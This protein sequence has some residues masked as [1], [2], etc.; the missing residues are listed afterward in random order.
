MNIYK[1]FKKTILIIT[2][3]F[4]TTNKNFPDEK[5]PE[6]N[7]FYNFL[8][9]FNEINNVIGNMLWPLYTFKNIF[10]TI[11]EIKDNIKTN[12][13]VKKYNRNKEELFKKYYCSI[14]KFDN[15]TEN[16]KKLDESLK[17]IVGQE[18]AMKIIK[19]TMIS[20]IEKYYEFDYLKEKKSEEL[21]IG[22]KNLEI[23]LQAKKTKNKEIKKKLKEYEELFIY[24][25]KKYF[26]L[27][28]GC[29]FIYLVGPAGT[30]KTETAIQLV[31]SL[32]SNNNPA[33][34]IDASTIL[35]NKGK[36]SKLLKPI[37]LNNEEYG[38][39][40]KFLRSDLD[41]YIR[42]AKRGVIIFN[43]IDKILQDPKLA[44]DLNE[45]LRGLKDNNYYIDEK[46]E[47]VDVSGFVFIFTSNEKV[48]KSEKDYTGS[49]TIVNSDQSLRTR[50]RI[51]RFSDF[52]IKEYNQLVNMYLEKVKDSFS[53]IYSELNIKINYEPKIEK[54]CS[55]YIFSNPEL[56]N[57]GA[58]AI[59]DVLG[60]DLKS[61]LFI[62]IETLKAEIKNNIEK[63]KINKE[64]Y[65]SFDDNI[66][67]FIVNNEGF[68]THENKKSI[69]YNRNKIH[70]NIII[71]LISLFVM[72]ILI[73]IS[74]KKIIKKK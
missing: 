4:C 59:Y 25:N 36:F 28:P 8:N 66:N 24:E 57:R 12:D 58:R 44:P 61:K 43:E 39:N 51:V 13:Y 32:T 64:I 31:R 73:S 50:F 41:T 62:N 3:I 56:K 60:D 68:I 14:G 29:T 5:L 69:V 6:T 20:L 19:K 10:F 67:E 2:L 9:R 74:T 16:I 1:I 30:G 33:Y 38:K 55:E 54:Y 7:C 26:S 53:E 37:K 72:F 48:D 21:K 22:L 27:G 47:K 34:V 40:M 65:I 23:E 42:T 17:K 11:K 52:N 49:R 35:N 70:K 46:G 71:I 15:C 63:D 18:E 45:T